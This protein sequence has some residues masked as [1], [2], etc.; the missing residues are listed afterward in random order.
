MTAF[1]DL[2]ISANSLSTS[3]SFAECVIKESTYHYGEVFGY[4]DGCWTY[5]K[6]V[7]LGVYGPKDIFCWGF[8]TSIDVNCAARNKFSW[9][10][11]KTDDS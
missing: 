6:C 4:K 3:V 8:Y 2:F 11:W 5:G 10:F 7:C 9:A 1:L